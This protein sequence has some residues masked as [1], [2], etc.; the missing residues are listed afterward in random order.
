MIHGIVL[1][2]ATLVVLQLTLE[3]F[4]VAVCYAFMHDWPR[5]AYWTCAGLI[6]LTTIF[7]GR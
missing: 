7:I 4:V 1:N 2:I 3:D 6:T 5:A